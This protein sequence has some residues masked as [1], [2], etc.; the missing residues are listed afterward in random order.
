MTEINGFPQKAE[1]NTEQLVFNLADEM[2]I[3][4]RLYDIK[5]SDTLSKRERLVGLLQLCLKA[6]N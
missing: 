5:A 2:G 1:Q 6:E 3:S 4:I